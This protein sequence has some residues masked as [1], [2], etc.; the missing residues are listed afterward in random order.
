MFNWIIEKLCAKNQ[1]PNLKDEKVISL[2]KPFSR[3]I[4]RHV[5]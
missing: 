3:Q 1:G 2:N 5:A 4:G